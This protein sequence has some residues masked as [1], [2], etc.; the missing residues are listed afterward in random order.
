MSTSLRALILAATGALV[1]GS[2]L[3][4]DLP[5]GK[6]APS[7]P[8]LQDGYDWTGFYAGAH[9]GFVWGRAGYSSTNEAGA[10]TGSGGFSVEQALNPAFGTGSFYNGMQL[11]YN[12]LLANRLLIG[13]EADF[14]ANTFVS[15]KGA[16]IG[17]SA[18]VLNGAAAYA[19]NGWD[20]ATLRARVG[21]APGN[22][23]FY[24][25]GGLAL[26]YENFSLV[27]N[28]SGVTDSSNVL[29]TGWAAGAGVELPV[30]PNW[31]ARLEY[32]YANYGKHTIDFPQG[33]ERFTATSL[34]TNA[35]RVG[36]NYQFGEGA[37]A[38]TSLLSFINPDN[39]AFHAQAT[40]TWQGYPAF[41]AASTGP[42]SLNSHGIGSE[43]NDADLFIGYHAWQGGE[44]W[45]NPE[46][47][48]GSGLGGT[49]GVVN[50]VNNEAYKIGLAEPYG[51]IQRF[52]LR[53][54]I[55]LGGATEKIDADLMHF[56]QTSTAD[57]LVL[58]LGRFSV[59]DI[60]DTNRYAN[61]PKTQFWNW[62]NTFNTTLDF[63]TD[64]WSYSY[65]GAAEYYF[66]RFTVRTGMFTLSQYP[67]TAYNPLG[68]GNDPN[69]RNYMGVVELEERHDLWGQPGK[70]KVLGY[71]DHGPMASYADAL[72]WG[73]ANGTT[74]ALNQVQHYKSKTGFTLNVE[75][76]IASDLGFFARAG[77]MDPR[78]E[79]YEACELY[80]SA[81]V[82][83]SLQGERWGRPLDT[84]GFAGVTGAAPKGAIAY[85]NAGGNLLETWEGAGN[86]TKAGPEK[87]LEAYYNY[88]LNTAVN[89]NVDYQFVA[90]PAFNTQRGP[91]NVFGAKVHWQF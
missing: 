88:Q 19:E 84:V 33:G 22:W 60:F 25:T 79:P 47:N 30:I 43:I 80:E 1:S 21:Y 76:Q 81:S 5:S 9:M 16:T 59:I 91:I 68:Y 41:N 20:S 63:G 44:F 31:T 90:N 7:A 15:P 78:Y 52:F 17:G 70:I 65:G 46:I 34:S 55:D 50:Y 75:Q 3:A 14:S 48:E 37:S 89:F 11:G 36:V 23:L 69:F 64:A 57:R 67:E 49:T 32:L 72:A 82:G 27:Q 18:Q 2:A 51:R 24:A 6:N 86:L 83:V 26:N 40:A 85:L 58:T 74:P 39:L 62:G 4:G 71:I 87:I 13:A 66:N 10:P 42:K 8:V 61:S 12:E 56:S 54:T 53:Q 45:F 77:W 29:R 35:L 38:S 28:A 73:I